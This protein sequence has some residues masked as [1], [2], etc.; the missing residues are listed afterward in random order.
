MKLFYGITFINLKALKNFLKQL[1]G[2]GGYAM[3]R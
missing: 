1:P 3:R 2:A